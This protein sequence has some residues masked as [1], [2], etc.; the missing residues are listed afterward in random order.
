MRF[1]SSPNVTDETRA[2]E[3]G[4]SPFE[5][6]EI[7]SA[8]GSYELRSLPARCSLAVWIGL[9]LLSEILGYGEHGVAADDPKQ[10]RRH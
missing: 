3:R 10:R 5:L 4:V 7:L 6:R 8:A 9:F 1:I 2:G